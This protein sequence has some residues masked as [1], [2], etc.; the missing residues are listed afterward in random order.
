MKR[1][2]K[3]ALEIIKHG[4][5]VIKNLDGADWSMIMSLVD[6]IEAQQFKF[7]IVKNN[8]MI[9]RFIEESEEY[10]EILWQLGYSTKTKK[11]VVVEGIVDFYEWYKDNTP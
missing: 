11:E 9:E 4:I 10:E 3:V 2:K 6:V 1:D 5:E 7:M 8:Y